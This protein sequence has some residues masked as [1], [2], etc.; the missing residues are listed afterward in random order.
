MGRPRL[1]WGF[2]KVS[3]LLLL[4]VA[5]TKLRACALVLRAT[6]KV[7]RGGGKHKEGA[8][9]TGTKHRD[10]IETCLMIDNFVVF[11]II[12]KYINNHAKLAVV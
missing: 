10:K 12:H 9:T 4:C 1:A 11:T 7:K 5:L 2:R 6:S 3:Y 8:R